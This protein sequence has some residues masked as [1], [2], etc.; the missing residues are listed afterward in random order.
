MSVFAASVESTAY[1]H[2]CGLWHRIWHQERQVVPGFVAGPYVLEMLESGRGLL[3][4]DLERAWTMQ[5]YVIG[6]YTLHGGALRVP[7]HRVT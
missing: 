6:V 3:R 5:Y 1:L 7:F 4:A 2:L